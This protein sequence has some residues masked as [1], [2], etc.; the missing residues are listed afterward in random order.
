[1]VLVGSQGDCPEGVLVK[2]I[3]RF[4]YVVLPI[5]YDHCYALVCS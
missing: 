4:I 2:E 3:V 1:M 5:H